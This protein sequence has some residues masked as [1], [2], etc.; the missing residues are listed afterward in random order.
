VHFDPPLTHGRLIRRYKRF[1]ADIVLENGTAVTAHCPNPGSMMD[2]ALPGRPVALSH[3]TRASRKLAYTWEMIEIDGVWVSIHTGRTNA[4]V[5]EALR[6]GQLPELCG[7]AELRREVRHGDS[8]LDFL[9]RSEDGGRCFMEVKSVT[10]TDRNGR[11]VFPD[12]VTLRGRKHLLELSKLATAGERAVMFYWVNRA[13]CGS[14]GP[15][16][17]ID[18]EYGRLLRQARSD[19]VEILA[20]RAEVAPKQVTVDKSIPIVL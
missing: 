1:L 15:A 5:E 9:L 16:D 2:L 12:S 6:S 18:P 20:Y 19:G 14:F 4:L 10:L 11:A 8:R 13:D 3:S 17:G 7:F